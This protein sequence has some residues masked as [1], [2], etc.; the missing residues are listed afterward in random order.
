MKCHAI[1]HVYYDVTYDHIW[2][3]LAL[4]WGIITIQNTIGVFRVIMLYI[5][6]I[7]QNLN[8]YPLITRH[9]VKIEENVLSSKFEF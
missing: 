5:E 8:I 4:R 1:R 7:I 6:V 9:T 2:W 3:C